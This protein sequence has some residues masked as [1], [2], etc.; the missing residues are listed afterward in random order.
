MLLRKARNLS[1]ETVFS[2]SSFPFVF[3]HPGCGNSLATFTDLTGHMRIR[4]FFESDLLENPR[5]AMARR[6]W[7][8]LICALEP[9]CNL[10]HHLTW[11][12]NYLSILER[13]AKRTT[14]RICLRPCKVVLA[15]LKDIPKGIESPERRYSHL[16]QHKS[17][18]VRIDH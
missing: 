3:N 11:G 10:L 15:P 17:A 6:T 12:S 18:T 5:S 13:M 7:M 16:K 4:V 9:Q 2:S 8:P 1:V 14:P